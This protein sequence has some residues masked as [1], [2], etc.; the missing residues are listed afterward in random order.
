[1][2]LP[3]AKKNSAVL[4]TAPTSDTPPQAKP[5]GWD[6]FDVWRT[7]ILLPRLAEGSRQE[8]PAPTVQLVR[9]NGNP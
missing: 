9:R 5:A 6:P 1:M 2:T 8:T 3:A 7:R 4:S